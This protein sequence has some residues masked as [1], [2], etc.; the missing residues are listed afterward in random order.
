VTLQ[1]AVR[2][3]SIPQLARLALQRSLGRLTG[4]FRALPDFIIIGAQRCGTTSLYNYL[5]EHPQVLPATIKETHFFDNNFRRGLNW[6]R[7]FFPL[8]RQMNGDRHLVT[9]ESTPY[10]LFYPHA[11]VRVY[12]TLP[13]VKLVVMLRNPVDRAFSHYYHE[14]RMGAEPLSFEEALDREERELASETARIVADE[15]YRSFFHQHHTYLSRGIY[16]DQLQHWTQVFAREQILA[17][18][19]EDFYQ[20]PAVTLRQVTD[21]LG[22]PPWNLNEYPLYNATRHGPMESHIRERLAAYF[23]PH[24]HRLYDFLG[25]NWKWDQGPQH[26]KGGLS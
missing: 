2:R 15:H 9:G 10:Y 3:Y 16:V 14:K 18:R 20:D 8:A 4:P 22:L 21:F 12:D 13:D 23:R 25:A 26:R 5:A 17:I 19:S 11:P 6:Y 7:A 1:R 24:N